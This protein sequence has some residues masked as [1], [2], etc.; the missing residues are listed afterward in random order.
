MNK[1]NKK[2]EAIL[3][4]VKETPKARAIRLQETEGGKKVASKSWGGRL[5]T[6]EL[7]RDNSWKKEI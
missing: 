3:E 4:W 6:K 7:R 5:N 1:R 2:T